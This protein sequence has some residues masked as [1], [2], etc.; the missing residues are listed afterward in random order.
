VKEEGREEKESG[1]AFLARR[2]DRLRKKK[3][4]RL[5]FGPQFR[6]SS[7]GRGEEPAL[8]DLVADCAHVGGKGGAEGLPS[9]DDFAER[10]KKKR[11]GRADGDQDGH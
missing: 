2:L 5:H 9:P 6:K 4:R 8:V 10:K 3:E 11:R 7:H 1:A